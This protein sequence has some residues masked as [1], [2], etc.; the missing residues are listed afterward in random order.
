MF[1][2][3][4]KLSTVVFAMVGYLASR[5]PA[6]LTRM[7]T[8][9]L[10]ASSAE[11]KRDFTPAGSDTSARTVMARRVVWLALISAATESAWLELEVQLMTS[12]APSETR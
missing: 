11:L 9:D 4:S 3:R 10:K 2:I 8:G 7:W 12:L 5:T 6:E 1:M